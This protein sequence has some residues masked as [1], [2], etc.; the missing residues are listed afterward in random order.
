MID[1]SNS[2]EV[3]SGGVL[4]K[5]MILEAKKLIEKN[6]APFFEIYP[7]W[8]KKDPVLKEFCEARI[9]NGFGQWQEEIKK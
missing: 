1:D 3:R 4:T 6:D 2:S 7:L 5:E 9:K 8:A